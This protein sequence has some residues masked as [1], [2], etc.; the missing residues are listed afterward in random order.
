MAPGWWVKPSLWLCGVLVLVAAYAGQAWRIHSLGGR[1][2]EVT[3]ERDLA[4]TRAR[5]L[6][7]GLEVSEG[8]RKLDQAA[9]KKAQ[10][11]ADAATKRSQETAAA[12]G[13]A[14]DAHD[15]AVQRLRA[16]LA[17]AVGPDRGGGAGAAA[18]P[19]GCAAADQAAGV[20]AAL[21]ERCGAAVR[22]LARFGDDSHDAAVAGWDALDQGAAPAR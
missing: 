12:A 17:A 2:A 20:F 5:T 9:A 3:A 1:V 10:E 15:R 11:D 7:E 14:G 8:R 19:G 16:S 13:A 21:L 22:V 6:A 18:A 4:T